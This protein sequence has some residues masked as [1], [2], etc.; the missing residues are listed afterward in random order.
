MKTTLA[1]LAATTALG[2]VFALTTLNLAHA[3]NR[4]TAADADQKSWVQLVS[5]D[6]DEGQDEDCE[7]EDDDDGEGEDGHDAACLPVQ[8]A[9]PAGT[10]APPANGLFGS[11]TPPKV[12]VN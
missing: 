12:Q 10:V 9:A 8:N 3:G 6:D 11:T 4:P 5:G 2:A 7:D 1:I